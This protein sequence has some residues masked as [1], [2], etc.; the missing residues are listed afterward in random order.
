MLDLPLWPTAAAE[1]AHTIDALYILLLF[2]A[3]AIALLVAGLVIGFSIRYRRG[4]PRSRRPLAKF[5]RQEIEVGWTLTT[6]LLAVAI[7]VW[8]IEQDATLLEPPRDSLQIHV[9]AKQWMWKVRHPDG[10]RE[11]NELHV[12]RG[13]DVTLLLN[14]EDVIHSFYVPAFRVKQDVVPGRTGEL[15]FKADRV[16]SYHLFCAEFCGTDHSAMTGRVVVME[17]EAYAEWLAGRPAGPGLARQGEELFES[18]GCA[19]CHVS[20]RGA[21]APNLDGVYGR[22][23]RLADGGR[24]EADERY[25]R[26]S[27]LL[28]KQEIVAGYRPIMPSF[29]G[30]VGDDDL[31]ALVAYLKSLRSGEE[32]KP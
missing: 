13:R 11:I 9:L 27:I 21:T 22:L 17:P 29:E 3:G 26:D 7:F 19:G 15:W 25:L 28:P 20:A 14:S 5:M 31:A 8:A 10:Q 16:G 2:F 4:S 6:L 1:S 12:P 24:V 18:L 30:I 23:V 32:A